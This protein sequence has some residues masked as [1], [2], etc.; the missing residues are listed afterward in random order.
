[1]KK[2]F[3]A[4][5]SL[6]FLL[7][8][9]MSCAKTG[10]SEINIADIFGE[11]TA[12]VTLPANTL[13]LAIEDLKDYYGIAPEKVSEFVAVQDSSGYKDEILIIKSVDEIAGQEIIEILTDYLSCQKESIRKYDPDQYKILCSSSVIKNGNYI[14][15]F[16]SAEQ[17]TM[18][19]IFNSYFKYKY[20]KNKDQSIFFENTVFIG[21]SLTTG[22]RNY[23]TKTRKKRE[24]LGKAEFLSQGGMC[25]NNILSDNDAEQVLPKWQGKEI[26]LFVGLEKLNAKKVFICLGLSDLL[27]SRDKKVYTVK[28][29]ENL[30][31]SLQAFDPELQIYIESIT[32]IISSRESYYFNNKNVD[33]LNN[34]LKILCK[35][36]NV[37][38]VDITHLFKDNNNCLADKYCTDQ[39]NWGVHL[40]DK[41]YTKW[42]KYLESE[43]C[44]K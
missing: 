38:F 30:I 3:I 12:S 10:S 37:F 18:E 4:I 34:E 2:T 17:N 31:K 35:K 36:N 5:L 40:T 13:E 32:P 1:M 28:N 21:D 42:V 39:N 7:V 8:I 22:L 43:F 9:L 41:A 15:M 19:D 27:Q 29:A 44:A 33:L 16:I 25:Y 6:V 26:D 14:A 11:I 20:R 23:V 24:C